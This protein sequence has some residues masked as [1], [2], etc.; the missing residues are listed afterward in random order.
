MTT[1]LKQFTFTSLALPDETFDVVSFSGT[2]GLSKL[3][4]FEIILMADDPAIS[5]EKVV[6]SRGTLTIHR[7]GED[8]LFNG[9]LK[10]FEQLDTVQGRTQYRASL[11]PALWRLTLTHH[12]QIFL[13]KTVPEIIE[14]ALGDAMMTNLDYELRLSATY[15][16]LEYVC[17]YDES[18]AAFISRLMEREGIYYYFEQDAAGEKLIITDILGVH[19][20]MSA[21]S[22]I[23]YPQVSGL[24]ES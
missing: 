6:Q 12:N 21:G 18:H 19:G 23:S 5:L 17:Q 24:D 4:H 13:N 2:E 14:A 10:S 9:I 11:A 1:T 3:Y 22:E 8:I 7:E 20:F 15:P 16:Q